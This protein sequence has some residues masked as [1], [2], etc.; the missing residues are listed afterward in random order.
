MSVSC[1]TLYMPLIKEMHSGTVPD[2]VLPTRPCATAL[3]RVA[4]DGKGLSGPANVCTCW[5]QAVGTLEVFTSSSYLPVIAFAGLLFFFLENTQYR[6]FVW[7]R[8]KLGSCNTRWSRWSMLFLSSL[9]AV[10]LSSGNFECLEVSF[11]LEMKFSRSRQRI[12]ATSLK[13][14]E[15]RR[16]VLI[17]DM[18][19]D[20]HEEL[21]SW[22]GGVLHAKVWYGWE[23]RCIGFSVRQFCWLLSDTVLVWQTRFSAW[24]WGLALAHAWNGDYEKFLASSGAETTAE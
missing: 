16:K 17:D 15:E 2:K 13:C 8:L 24:C 3:L 10:T 22:F 14:L 6:F 5:P 11:N 18:S 19:T 12:L 9:D 4:P 7:S 21:S 1:L 20:M 23:V